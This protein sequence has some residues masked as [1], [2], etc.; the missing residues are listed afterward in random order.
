[1]PLKILKPK[2]TFT[3]DDPAALVAQ[4][5][6]GPRTREVD[7]MN[8]MMIEG[9]TMEGMDMSGHGEKKKVEEGGQ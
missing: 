3:V 9:S 2:R 1:M 6:F 8:L 5:G 7:M 4:A